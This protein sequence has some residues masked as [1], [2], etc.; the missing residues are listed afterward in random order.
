MAT[1][2]EMTI[3]KI[4]KKY[5]I[6]Q[7]ELSRRF[8]IPLRTVQSWHMGERKPREYDLKMIIRILELEDHLW[9][10][11]HK[12]LQNAGAEKEVIQKVQQELFSKENQE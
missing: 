7:A 8:G 6:G 1:K 11:V 2:C 4:C 5:K 10:V 3:E 12:A 9:S